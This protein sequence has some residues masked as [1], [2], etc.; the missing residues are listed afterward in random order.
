MNITQIRTLYDQ[1]QRQQITYPGQRREETDHVVRQINTLPNAKSGMVEYS[2]LTPQNADDII[3]AEIAYFEKMGCDFEWKAYDYDSPPD[4]INRLAAHGFTIE[5]KEAIVV[6]D[7]EDQPPILN[8]TVPS[9]VKR[10]TDPKQLTDVKDI[11]E[12]VW[13]NSFQRHINQ[14]TYELIENP[15]TISIYVAYVDNVPASCAWLTWYKPSQF[16]GLWGGATLSQ[17]RKQGL[18]SALVAA[19]LQEAKQKG[20]RFTTVDAMPSSRP[21]LEKIGFRSIGYSY[22]C[23]WKVQNKNR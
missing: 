20:I 11:L 14:L 23:K 4:L 1:Q 9:A 3:K 21:I 18:Y 5:E 12:A 2:T 22:P 10:L 7:L 19:R 13:Q 8:Y 15:H 16:A 6:L 17:Y